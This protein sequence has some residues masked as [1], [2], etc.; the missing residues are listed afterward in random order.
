MVDEIEIDESESPKPLGVWMAGSYTAVVLSADWST[1][2]FVT[3][4]PPIKVHRVRLEFFVLEWTPRL[5]M[6]AAR[7]AR[8][9]LDSGLARHGGITNEARDALRD[10]AGRSPAEYAEELL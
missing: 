9:Y 2:R 7:V 4:E 6:P 5:D 10:L 3:F 1:V 8:A